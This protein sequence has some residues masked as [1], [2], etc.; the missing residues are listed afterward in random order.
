VAA[1]VF[2]HASDLAVLRALRLAGVCD[3]AG[4]AT[5]LALREDAARRALDLVAEQGYAEERPRG[6]VLTE[7]GREALADA[8]AAERASVP[9]D[10]ARR[11]YDAFG[12]HDRRFKAMVTTWQVEG[13]PRGASV[14]LAVFHDEFAP[15]LSRTVHILPRLSPFP[16]RFDTA[17][18]RA[19]DGDDR[20]LV[21]P[22]V[23]SYHTIWFELHEELLHLRGTTREQE[24]AGSAS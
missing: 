15:L 9:P 24:D 19:A 11:L 22:A 4:L 7:I 21:H 16:V 3:A 6:F 8:L 18:Q 12:H 1:L 20:Y 14:Q 10:A 5:R 13:R 23:D 2:E 17:L